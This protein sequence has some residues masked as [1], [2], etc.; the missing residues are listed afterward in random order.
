MNF[1]EG[2]V[3]KLGEEVGLYEKTT[4]DGEF[5]QLEKLAEATRDATSKLLKEITPEEQSDFLGIHT[6]CFVVMCSSQ[7]SK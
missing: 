2:L 4:E 3:Q 5:G 6:F 7:I 1:F